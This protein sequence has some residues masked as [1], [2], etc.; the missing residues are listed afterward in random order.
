MVK[1]KDLLLVVVAVVVVAI[2]AAF[3]SST[4][5]GGQTVSTTLT[6]DFYDAPAPI[7]QGNTT[8]WTWNGQS[9]TETTSVNVTGHT[10]WV[11]VGLTSTS[12]CQSQL[13][14]AKQIGNFTVETESQPLGVLITSIGGDANLQ[15]EGRA[16]QYYVNG[17]Y[18]NHAVNLYTIGNGDQVVWKYIPNQTS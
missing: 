11:F 17:V 16:W 14:A 4:L 3:Y 6:I 18:A 7:H 9:W 12:D 8:T 1:K 15:Y 2:T 10:V 5:S 13:M